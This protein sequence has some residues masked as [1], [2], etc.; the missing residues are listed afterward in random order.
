MKSE[1]MQSETNQVEIVQ[2]YNCTQFGFIFLN[3]LLDV[4]MFVLV[5]DSI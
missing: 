5:R 1:M 2:L 4:C 3:A